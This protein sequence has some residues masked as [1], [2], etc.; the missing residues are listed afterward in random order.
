[1]SFAD[2]S[3]FLE[4]TLQ[5]QMPPIALKFVKHPPQDIPSTAEPAPSSCAFWRRAEKELFYASI[6]DHLNCPLGAMVMGFPLP[7]KQM[8]QLQNEV[9][10]M[11][12]LSY[13][14]E[15]EVPH[16]PRMAGQAT[17]GIV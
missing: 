11:C 2:L 7:D 17:G 4:T 12:G 6:A 3:K 9:G 14:R 10:M 16:V 13:V 1:M 8:Q 5:L 15:D